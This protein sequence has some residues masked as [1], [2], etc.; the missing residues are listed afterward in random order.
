MNVMKMLAQAQ[1]MQG[2]LAKVQEELKTRTV[3]ATAGGGAVS[4]VS[5]C[6]GTIQSIR[7]NP[8]ILKPEDAEMVADL[9][10]TAVR[11]A[12]ESGRKVSAEEIGK[13]TKGMDMPGLNLGL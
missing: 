13:V 11:T 3:E 2:Q 7:I 6:E 9:V 10:L 4:V 8:E 5:N 12:Q 1:K